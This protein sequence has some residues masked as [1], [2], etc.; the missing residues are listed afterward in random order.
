MAE[1]LQPIRPGNGNEPPGHH[2]PHDHTPPSDDGI[3]ANIP[4]HTDPSDLPPWRQA[5][6]SLAQSPEQL[7]QDLIDH[8]CPPDIAESALHSPYSGMTA[9]D[10]LDRFWDPKEGTWDWPKVNGFAD[11]KWETARSISP[12][13]WLDRIGEVSAKSGDF[14]GDVGDPY[15]HRGLAPGTSGDYHV[16]QGTGKQL[17]QG[18]E[19]RFG[20]VGEAFGWPG[21]GIQWVVF[22]TVEKKT[23]LIE[24]LLRRGYLR[25]S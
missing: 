7:V 17:P 2:Q 22:D 20:K 3:D 11:G 10:I 8:G 16:F 5:Q 24:T 14:M 4:G 12:N 1:N 19:V 23:V 15:S 18:W 9:Q 13:V 21:G 25:R 6:L